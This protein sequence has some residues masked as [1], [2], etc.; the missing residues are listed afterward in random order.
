MGHRAEIK[1]NP[2]LQKWLQDD[3]KFPHPKG[4]HC[5][6]DLVR[7]TFVFGDPFVLCLMIKA[8]TTNYEV[9]RMVNRLNDEKVDQPPNVNM[10]LK[11]NGFIVEIQFLLEDILSIKHTLH[12][13]YD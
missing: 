10:N 4:Q 7:A 5:L 12:K 1:S 8:L 6:T 9:T 11:I 3:E 13:Y 2:T